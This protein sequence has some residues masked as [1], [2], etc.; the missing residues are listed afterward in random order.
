MQ[1]AL[2]SCAYCGEKLA[3]GG[4]SVTCDGCETGFHIVC[5]ERADELAVETNSRLLRSDV[6]E[7][8]C[9]DCG[10]S[11]TLSFDPFE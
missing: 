3:S 4:R 2:L 7:I 9:P 10:E 8:T 1:Q 11:W 6:H 5:A